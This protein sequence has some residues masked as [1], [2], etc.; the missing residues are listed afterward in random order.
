MSAA[1]LDGH[2]K[3][4]LAGLMNGHPDLAVCADHF[5]SQDNAEIFKSILAVRGRGIAPALLAV[6][7]DLNRRG[8]LRQVGGIAG[9]TQLV[10]LPTDDASI[11]YALGEVLDASDSRQTI[12]IG[13]RL[14]SGSIT[15]DA[16]EK[17]LGEL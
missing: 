14:T 7:D 2:E 15:P 9:L 11:N 1:F 13:K 16:A 8:K 4:V 3:V 6:Q 10:G 17:E 5:A 12:S